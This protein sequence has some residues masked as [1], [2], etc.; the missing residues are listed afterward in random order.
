M[1]WKKS[2]FVQFGWAFIAVFSSAYARKVVSAATKQIIYK[3]LRRP[4]AGVTQ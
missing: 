3:I 2:V 1:K 4:A